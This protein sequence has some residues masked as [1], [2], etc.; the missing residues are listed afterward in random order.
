V[1]VCSALLELSERDRQT[2]PQP[3]R[4]LPSAAGRGRDQASPHGQGQK[5]A[6]GRRGQALLY[7]RRAGPRSTERC[8]ATQT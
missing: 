2:L 8:A 3:V 5:A 6:G 1:D 4:E 7:R